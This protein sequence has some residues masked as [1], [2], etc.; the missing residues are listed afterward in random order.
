MPLVVQADDRPWR[1]AALLPLPEESIRGLI[2][3]LPVE[4]IL[5][6]A[7][8]RDGLHTTLS[9]ADL[10]LGDWTGELPLGGAEAAVADRLAFVQQPGVGVETIDL[11]AFAARGVPV[12]NCAGA[13]AVSV[14]EWCLGASFALL[15]SLVWAD[16]QV[17]AGRWPNLGIAQRGSQ[18]LAG[19]RVGLVGFGPIGVECAARYA[20]LGCEVSYWSRHRRPP[21]EAAGA[22][23]RDFDELLA[24]SELLVV[25][26]ALG[27]QSRGLL[28][29]DRL[30]TLP[31]GAFLLNAAR[32]GIVDEAA[33]A[34]AV[35]S[36]AL[37]GAAFDVYA[38]EP[39]AANSPLRTSDRVLLSPH[40]AGSSQQ[41]LASIV[42]MMADN[43]RRA[44]TGEPVRAVR[45][46]V[47]P[48]VRRRP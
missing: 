27:D 7:R 46:A 47:D 45:N 18:E 34:A 44:V 24:T 31:A 30:A 37:A 9:G 19:K 40:A 29:A 39:L 2:G 11:Q 8:D 5:P 20:A 38:T 17:R 3:D 28:D 25:V 23:Y 32:G 42:A 16:G 14:A 4:L 22:A 12:A 13:N 35:E 48:I 10:V 1:L 21:P 43:L 36:G 26:I 15:R 6:A 33:V 41:A